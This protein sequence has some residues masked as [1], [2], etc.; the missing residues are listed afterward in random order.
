[1]IKYCKT[2]LFPNTKPDLFFNENGVCDSCI[3][4]S[5][6]HGLS[7][8]KDSN[9]DWEA[10]KEEL[11]TFI[12]QKLKKN[13]SNYDCIVPVSGGKDSTWQV[14]VAKNILKLKVLAITFDQFDQTK[15]GTHNLRVLKEIGVDHF[16]VTM[17]PLIIKK[18]VKKGLEIIGDPYWVNHVGMFTVPINIASKF[19]I[20]IILYG[21]NPQFEYG[22]PT[23]SRS[24]MIMD[25]RW[26]Q[27]F[28]GMRGLR[29]EDMVDHEI[30][31]SDLSLLQYPDNNLLENSDI[32][33][34]FL[35]YFM[36]WN[37]L[38]HTE[39]VKKIGWKPLEKPPAGSWSNIENCDMRFID[40][41]ERIKFLKYGYGR[42]TD[43]LNIAIRM[44]EMSRAQALS[45]VKKIDG[46]VDGKNLNDFANFIDIQKEELISTIESFVN[47]NIFK[48]NEKNELS[49]LIERY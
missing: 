43:Q 32:T 10:R 27:E 47:F 8:N 11:F 41:R 30:K 25:K 12:E 4:A 6:K 22:G 40:I 13:K 7:D 26:R 48:R 38:E 36:K 21:E 5:M 18:L 33:S 15:T 1:M 16:H 28:S 39:F 20:P 24:K 44:N 35:G 46:Q 17:N 45:I 3:S 31:L 42:A 34:I 14:F 49:E 29:E 2:C 19:S 23:D 37:P 9:I